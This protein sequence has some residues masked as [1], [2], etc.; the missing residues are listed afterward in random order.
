MANLHESPEWVDGIYQLTD[1]TP[2]LGK[3][4][5]VTGDGPSNLQAKQLADRTKWLRMMIESASDYRE[6]TFFKVPSDPDGTIAGL[7][8]TP[9]GKVF[10]VAQGEDNARSFVYYINKSGAAVKVAEMPG[11]GVISLA[12]N[13][14]ARLDQ[15]IT[16]LSPQSL[17]AGKYYDISTGTIATT[18]DANWSTCTPVNVAGFKRLIVT[19]TFL[20]RKTAA[21]I[22]FIDEN[23]TVISVESMGLP[24]SED[25]N[26]TSVAEYQVS[27][28]A[29]AVSALTSTYAEQTV[30]VY[31]ASSDFKKTAAAMS[32]VSVR[33]RLVNWIKNTYMNATTGALVTNSDDYY[34]TQI[35][36]SPGDTF[37]ISCKL[38]GQS[39]TVRLVGFL[40]AANN[41]IGAFYPGPGITTVVSISNLSFRVPANAVA[42]IITAY[43][44]DAST[45]LQQATVFDRS[46]TDTQ[47]AIDVA[48]GIG[49]HTS[50]PYY[51]G[52]YWRK[53]DGALISI[54]DAPYCAFHPIKV[55]P[56]EKY[57]IKTNTFTGN[58]SL[59]ALIV[60]KGANGEYIGT[61]E[62]APGSSVF[63]SVDITVTVPAG[64][65]LMLLTAYSPYIDVS[66]QGSD[67]EKLTSS[68]TGIASA[69]AEQLNIGFTKGYYWNPT[70][71]ALSS[72]VD[73]N[74]RAFDAIAVSPGEIYRITATEF[75]GSIYLVIFKDAGGAVVGKSQLGPGGTKI[76]SVD[77]PVTVPAGAVSMCISAYTD[78]V[79]I[80]KNVNH[81]ADLRNETIRNDFESCLDLLSPK[82]LDGFYW[83]QETGVRTII[84]NDWSY[85]SVDP[86]NVKEGETYR[87]ICDKFSGNP[88]L[89]YLVLFKDAAGSVIGRSNAGPGSGVVLSV[90][91]NVTVPSGAVTMC[92]TSYSRN[93]RVIKSGSILSKIP[94]NSPA[95]DNSPLDY[96][97]GKKIVWLGTSIPAGSGSNAYPY[98]LAQRLGANIVNRSVGSSPIRGGLDAFVTTDDP[99]GWTG[100]LYTR[101]TRA[102]SHSNAIKQ[103]F[104]DNYDSKWKSRVNGGPAILSD[105]D[106]AAILSNS[107]ENRLAG[108]LDADLF[109]IDHGINDYLWLEER[110]GD[111]SSLLTP[112]V[113]TRDINTFYGG[114]NVVIDYILSQNPRA[115]ILLIG[116]YENN[117]RP[118]IAQI[119]EKSAQL[120]E[121]PLVR[122]WEKTGW[123]QQVLTGSNGAGKTITEFWLPDNLHPHKDSTGKANTLLADI[124]EVE[125]R[126]VR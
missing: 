107:Y 91:V 73:P 11:T 101:V 37:I 47:M 95:Q 67:V 27:I 28:P 64:A 39:S 40:D 12:A 7:K 8:N 96:W 55:N 31:G 43:A 69:I 72:T 76:V 126:S 113:E 16:D 29:K 58:P 88:S 19:G 90:D 79:I 125:I 84:T 71:G 85:F 59:V 106:K 15:D 3:Q 122:M 120:W 65:A 81:K 52:R 123:S 10:R 62:V 50:L 63:V 26:F 38:K 1:E 45:V 20:R 78:K 98:M 42:M 24:L 99:Y 117:L 21:P 102:L 51:P 35:P 2:V 75:T 22:L 66:A 54:D 36:V 9:D 115:R 14:I 68:V 80:S 108:N 18:A 53:M 87:I 56:G 5:G 13:A 70:S 124:L 82:G 46:M 118:Q 25:N 44:V 57:R 89:V 4:E 33:N 41:L 77:V 32:S 111:L 61:S 74:W 114:M 34:T 86:V 104:I 112:P 110:G 94:G 92:I 30:I 23:N 48:S 109:V 49:K 116:F 17:G 6:Y 105:S 100:S 103:E 119:Q 121:Y 93:L 83:R 97:K 60:F